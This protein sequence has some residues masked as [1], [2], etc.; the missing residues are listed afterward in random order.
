[1]ATLKKF[2]VGGTMAL[3]VLITGTNDSAWA[4]TN[5]ALLVAVSD[6][7]N[8]DKQFWLTGPRNDAQLVRSFLLTNNF[9]KFEPSNVITLAD[10]VEGAGAPT[11]QGIRDAMKRI[12]GELEPGD[13]VYLHFSGHGS[14]APAINPDSELDGLDELFLPAD[15]G[16]WN[17]TVGTVE[18]A[19]V[20]DEIG[21]MIDSLRKKGVTVWAVFDSCHSGTV[22]RGTPSGS[23]EDREVSRKLT[24]DALAIPDNRMVEADQAT[25]RGTSTKKLET[26]AL[27]EGISGSAE[28]KF[29]AFYA[30]QTN[31]TTPEMRLPAGKKG[32]QSHGLFTYTLF[33][34]LAQ[35]PG[36]T[37]RQLGQEILRRY[38]TTYRVQPT[39]L[40]EGDLDGGVF[41]QDGAEAVRQW[42]LTQGGP[43][44]TIPAGQIH[45]LSVGDELLLMNSPADADDAAVAKLTVL[46]T[47]SLSSTVELAGEAFIDLPEFAHAR[48]TTRSLDFA[49]KVA[50]PDLGTL[51]DD[52]R[53][54]VEAAIETIAANQESGL[55]LELVAAGEPA[56]LRLAAPSLSELET[57]AGA[58][59]AL[60]GGTEHI[61]LLPPSGA[62]TVEGHTKT[63]SIAL[64]DPKT[65]D[66]LIRSTD[67]VAAILSDSLARIARTNNLLKLGDVTAP[68]ELDL[69]V[70]L[71]TRKGKGQPFSNLDPAAVAALVPGD[72]VHFEAQ[73]ASTSPL[74]LNVLYVGSDYSIS[75]MW[76]GRIKPGETLKKGLLRI[77]DKSFGREKLLLITTQATPQSTVADLSWLTQ[78]ALERTRAADTE[79]NSFNGLLRQSGFGTTT[80]GAAPLDDEKEGGTGNIAQIEIQTAPA[81]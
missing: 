38:S 62:I 80:R 3:S 77:N 67:D 17:D 35:S 55:R 23:G 15:I 9:T 22:T 65:N 1:M 60:P 24:A 8:L 66:G 19:L 20:D 4:R 53:A 5:H 37:Y 69:V 30:A 14:Q 63:F 40:F 78:G 76:N 11:L 56:D 33:E 13:F 72:E 58:P 21:T 52:K 12:E 36:I 70:K 47:T 81:N 27:V 45:G 49:L 34:T 16:P 46:E 44:L 48:Q 75:F 32:R 54:I 74:D 26:S 64:R 59:I 39:P 68:G 10:G 51:A 42:Q 61:W 25:T 7:P 31:E 2:V 18:N 79:I 29:V 50:R 28:G 73:N 71:K 43:T 57:L 6:Y 41:G